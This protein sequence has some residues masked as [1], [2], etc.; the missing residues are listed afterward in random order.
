MRRI[1]HY[2]ME[3]FKEVDILVTPTIGDGVLLLRIL[4]SRL[5]KDLPSDLQKL[6]CKNKTNGAKAAP[7]PSEHLKALHLKE[8]TPKVLEELKSLMSLNP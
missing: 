5:S 2:H 8:A 7:V 3:I 4:D 6:R 1:M